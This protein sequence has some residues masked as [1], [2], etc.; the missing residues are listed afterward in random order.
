MNMG[1]YT[2]EQNANRSSHGQEIVGETPPSTS[3]R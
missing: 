2:I 1:Q 3:L